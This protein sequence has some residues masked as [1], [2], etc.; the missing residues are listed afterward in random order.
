MITIEHDR[1]DYLVCRV[2]GKLTKGDYDAAV[3]E[4]ENALRLRPDKL[5]LMIVLEGFL[6][7]E[8][9]ALWEDLKFDVRH[10][11]DFGRIAVLGERRLEAWGTVLSKPFIGA[12]MRFFDI[13]ERD[14]AR[15]WLLDESPAGETPATR[16]G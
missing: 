8:I 13:E 7:W 6:G 1:R 4:L 2:G 14:A 3:P 15:A 11:N 9:G 5:R 16:A 10:R 12:E